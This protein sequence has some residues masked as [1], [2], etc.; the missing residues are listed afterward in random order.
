MTADDPFYRCEQQGG[1]AV[2][3]LNVQHPFYRTFLDLNTKSR[4]P[5]ELLIGSMALCQLRMTNGEAKTIDRYIK[6]V[7]LNLRQLFS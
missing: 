1:V 2:V 7:S 3:Y 5:L 4:E 6:E